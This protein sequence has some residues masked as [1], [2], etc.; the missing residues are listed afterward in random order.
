MHL[1]TQ[2]EKR[3]ASTI[4]EKLELGKNRTCAGYSFFDLAVFVD[5][6]RL[7]AFGPGDARR[8]VEYN[9]SNTVKRR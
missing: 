5:T 6:K 4:I 1:C 9:M 2:K 7:G 8:S 3:D